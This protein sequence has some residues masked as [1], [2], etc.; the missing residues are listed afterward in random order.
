M[1][2]VDTIITTMA[3]MMVVETVVD[4]IETIVELFIATIGRGH[5]CG[6]NCNA[7]QKAYIKWA[8]STTIVAHRGHH[9]RKIYMKRILQP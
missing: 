7:D 1:T 5:C 9:R 3:L 6:N 2:I 8:V 4:Q